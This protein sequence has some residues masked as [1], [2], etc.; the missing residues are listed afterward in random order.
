MSAKKNLC[1]ALSNS[2][3]IKRSSGNNNQFIAL[4]DFDAEVYKT[5]MEQFKL[6]WS[7]K[8]GTKVPKDTE[9]IHNGRTYR[10]S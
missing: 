1:L 6:T 10:N 3:Q 8:T 4:F 5:P 2:T 9:V 7:K